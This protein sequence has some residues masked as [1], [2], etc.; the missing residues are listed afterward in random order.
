MKNPWLSGFLSFIFPGLGHIYLG[1]IKKGVVLIL[2]QLLAIALMYVIIGFFLW[3]ILWIYSI[4]SSIKETKTQSGF[5]DFI[6]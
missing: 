2:S 5:A 4:V 1:K 6:K 3:P